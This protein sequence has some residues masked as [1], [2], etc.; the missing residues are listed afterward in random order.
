MDYIRSDMLLPKYG[1]CCLMTSE[2]LNLL[3]L[4]SVLFEILL[5][6]LYVYINVYI[7]GLFYFI[8]LILLGDTS[9]FELL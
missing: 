4:L 2:L 8:V 7:S 6:R 3:L 5:Y 1:I 9:S